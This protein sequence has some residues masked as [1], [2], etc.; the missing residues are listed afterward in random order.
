MTRL[1]ERVAQIERDYA[2]KSEQLAAG[3]RTATAGL[4]E[5]VQEDVANV[6]QAVANLRYDNGRQLVGPRRG[7]RAASGRRRRQ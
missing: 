7:G 6:K 4:R 1:N 5:E 2:A 3:K